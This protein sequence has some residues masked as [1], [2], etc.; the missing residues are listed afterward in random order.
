MKVLDI[1]D[2]R[3]MSIAPFATGNPAGTCCS[4]KEEDYS[5]WGCSIG[6]ELEMSTILEEDA[7]PWA[8]SFNN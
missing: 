5:G 2:E 6:D 3:I 8:A 7:S 1:M 4:W